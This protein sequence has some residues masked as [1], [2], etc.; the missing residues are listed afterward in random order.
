MKRVLPIG[1]D[2]IA[3]YIDDNRIDLIRNKI[4]KGSILDKYFF[5]HNKE[6]CICENIYKLFS[7]E[8]IKKCK[9]SSMKTY[10]TQKKVFYI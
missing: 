5:N 7:K 2:R 6:N 9:C 10:N 8:D 1:E 3:K 4:I